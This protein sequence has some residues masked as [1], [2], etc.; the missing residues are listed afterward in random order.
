M[1]KARTGQ[2]G[3]V[4]GMAV[5]VLLLAGCSTE[6]GGAALD[7][8]AYNASDGIRSIDPAKATD[9]ETLWVVDQLYEGLLELGEDLEVRPALAERWSVSADGRVYRFKLRGAQFHDGS[10]VTASDVRASFD[11]LLDPN[12]ALPGRWVLKGLREGGIRTLGE[13]SLELELKA[14]NPVFASLLATPNAAIVK[15]GGRHGDPDVEDLGSGPFQLQGWLPETAMV[16]H[17]HP[18]YWMRDEEGK[19]LPYLD[20]VRIEFNREIGGEMLGFEQGRYDLVSSPPPEWMRVLFDDEGKWRPDWAGRFV[21]HSVPFLKTDYIGVLMDTAALAG[22][23]T[24]APHVDLRRAMSMALDRPALVREFRAGLA[25]PAQGFVPPG[26]PGFGRTTHAD[27]DHDP[28]R[29]RQLL[30]DLGIGPEGPLQRW[31]AGVLGTKP[32]TAELAAALQFTWA[33]FGIDV[34]VDVAPSGIDAERVAKSQVPLFR[35]SWLADYPDAENFLGLFLSERWCPN[36]PNY[37]HFSSPVVDS[38]LAAAAQEGSREARLR[39]LSHAEQSVLAEMPVIPLWHDDVTHLVSAEWEGW[40]I[41]STNRLD[42][43]RVRRTG[44]DKE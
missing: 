20:G 29:A 30:G 31:D 23:G 40:S 38:L 27:L 44:R 16:L 28:D 22:L 36:G 1:L 42:L 19:G 41:Q 4:V 10:P 35:K 18:A 12:E 21:R 43:R 3:S 24:A 6:E 26:M 39:S 11:R 15:G 5:A 7:L 9:L 8:F 17:R 2:R 13:D 34:A 25:T 33:Q 14:P 37:T 32:E